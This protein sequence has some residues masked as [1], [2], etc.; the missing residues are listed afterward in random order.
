MRGPPLAVS[1]QARD[2]DGHLQAPHGSAQHPD[3]MNSYLRRPPWKVAGIDYWV[4]YPAGT[5]LSD[6]QGLSGP[7]I[8]VDTVN[9]IVT[10]ND[11]EGT[12]IDAVDFSLHGG[13][14][15]MFIGSSDAVVTNSNFGFSIQNTTD[16]VSVVRAGP[17]SVNLTVTNCVI[18]GFGNGTLGNQGNSLIQSSGGGKIVVKYNW[19]KNLRRTLS[20]SRAATSTSIT[21]ST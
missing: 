14:I 7:G 9:R 20:N 5:V 18:D 11:T 2:D 13:A 19:L 21:A 16:T 4:G 10:V 12:I 3:L 17:G 15:L 8:R 6:W 1:V